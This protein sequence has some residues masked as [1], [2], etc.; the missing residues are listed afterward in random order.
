MKKLICIL[1]LILGITSC[2]SNDENRTNKYVFTKEYSTRVIVGGVIGIIER[3]FKIGEIYN[4]TDNNNQFITIRIAEH[5]ELNNNCPSN[6]C[7]QELLNVPH[8]FLE[9]AE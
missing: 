5:S 7:Y 9:L 3:T 6:T 1:I 2:N 4:G 8:K